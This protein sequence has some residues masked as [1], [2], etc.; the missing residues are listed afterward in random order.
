MEASLSKEGTG[1]RLEVVE[2]AKGL[3][4]EL[5]LLKFQQFMKEQYRK[6]TRLSLNQKP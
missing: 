5:L 1:N 4:L 2:A 6:K 3:G